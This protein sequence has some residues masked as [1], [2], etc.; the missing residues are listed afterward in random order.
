MIIDTQGMILLDKQA[1]LSWI[2]GFYYPQN[3]KSKLNTKPSN[4]QSQPTN[5]TQNNGVLCVKFGDLETIEDFR[6]KND[7]SKDTSKTNVFNSSDN[8]VKRECD[9]VIFDNCDNCENNDNDADMKTINDD[10]DEVIFRNNKDNTR[11]SR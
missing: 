3:D 7:P 5:H 6:T 8:C 4:H 9:N 11:N 1:K 2:I 10:E